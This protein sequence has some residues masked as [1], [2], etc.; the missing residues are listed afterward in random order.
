[1]TIWQNYS[2]KLPFKA[3]E[4][5]PR[6][7]FTSKDVDWKKKLHFLRINTDK[8]G[9]QLNCYFCTHISEKDAP[10]RRHAQTC[11]VFV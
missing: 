9:H 5:I 6:K 4:D 10:G 1:M 2:G 11:C 3:P 8:E 7:T